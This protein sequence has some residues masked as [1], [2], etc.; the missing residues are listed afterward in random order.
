MNQ[1]QPSPEQ[2]PNRQVIDQN[3]PDL[4]VNIYEEMGKAMQPAL[5]EHDDKLAREY[6]EDV[7]RGGYQHELNDLYSDELNEYQR[8]ALG[9]RRDDIVFAQS[10]ADAAEAKLA[11]PLLTRDERAELTAERDEWL[12]VKAEDEEVRQDAVEEFRETILQPVAVEKTD[13]RMSDT[14]AFNGIEEKEPT[15]DEIHEAYMEAT[16]DARETYQNMLIGQATRGDWDDAWDRVRKA[17]VA[18]FKQRGEDPNDYAERSNQLLR[19]IQT[20]AIPDADP[21]PPQGG[22][23][24]G[25]GDPNRNNNR[26]GGRNGG[27]GG[28]RNGRGGRNNEG[29]EDEKKRPWGKIVGIAGAAAL[30]A[31]GVAFAWKTQNPDMLPKR[32]DAMGIESKFEAMTF[33]QWMDFY[34]MNDFADWMRGHGAGVRETYQTF[35]DRFAS[36]KAPEGDLDIPRHL[37]GVDIEVF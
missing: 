17:F 26:R 4:N 9:T 14:M 28:R 15:F 13:E 30:A 36:F 12:G 31:A 8:E 21:T 37:P 19:H 29:H 34:R 6:T 1:H 25:P 23:P 5:G 10:Q 35:I 22:N 2:L 18:N 20:I 33:R 7:A 27:R 3:D 11:N 16:R 32:G 24:G